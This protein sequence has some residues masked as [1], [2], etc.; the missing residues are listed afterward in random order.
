[1]YVLSLSWCLHIEH[2]RMCEH[3]VNSLFIFQCSKTC[4]GGWKRRAVVCMDERG[5]S[6]DCEP[7]MQPK[8]KEPCENEPCPIWRHGEWN[9]V[10]LFKSI[11]YPADKV[12]LYNK[13]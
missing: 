8:D 3:I 2:V 9:Q 12:K 5:I 7:D 1:M 11:L 4:G 13:V 10:I 6:R